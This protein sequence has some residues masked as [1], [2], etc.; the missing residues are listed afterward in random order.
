MKCISTYLANLCIR[1][2]IIDEMS[3]EWC[4]YSIEKRI[5]TMVTWIVIIFIGVYCFGLAQSVAFIL[6][7]LW[8][9][10]YT[11]GYH[12][13][14]Y[15][16]CLL[17]SVFVEL[18][19]IS[20]ARLIPRDMATLVL[21]FSNILILLCSPCNDVKIHLKLNEV[22]ALKLRIKKLLLLLNIIYLIL[23]WLQSFLSNHVVM[24]LV[25]D[26]VSLMLTVSYDQGNGEDFYAE[27][28]QDLVEKNRSEYD[29]T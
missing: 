9:R 25:A 22:H 28:K 1:F 19:C 29:R 24:A 26:A 27:N 14:S 13:S 10:K 17:L 16:G 3:F 15:I 18:F 2:D 23:C 4:V 20:I 6:P 12:A 7:F 11:N 5:V 21:L 8:L